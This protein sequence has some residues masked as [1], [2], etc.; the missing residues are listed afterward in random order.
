L[1][2]F[3]E[4]TKGRLVPE[5]DLGAGACGKVAVEIPAAVALAPLPSEA[6]EVA[7]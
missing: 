5:S 4:V 6:E 3:S 7:F 2:G 1:G